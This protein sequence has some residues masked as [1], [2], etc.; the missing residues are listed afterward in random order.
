VSRE[1][2]QEVLDGYAAA[3]DPALVARYDSLDP[4]R[5]Y[6]PVIDLLPQPGA[7]VADIGAGT[8]RDA[9]WLA[10]RGCRVV[11]V[12]PVA[13]L[14]EAGRAAH[15]DKDIMWIDDRLPA[16]ARLR[17]LAPFDAMILCA[18]WHH[19]DPEDRQAA[20]PGLA[21]AMAPGAML[22]LSLRH[23]PGPPDRTSFPAPPDPTI[24]AARAC[25]LRMMRRREAG[26]VSEESRALGVRWTWLAFARA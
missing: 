1:S 15:G 19:L 9:A 23:E 25:G 17:A 26:S 12:E 10:E 24:Y 5:I 21:A 20:L 8:G 18:V 4:E 6:A 22:I 2:I 16:L 11:A 7:R 3:A 13:A 14:R